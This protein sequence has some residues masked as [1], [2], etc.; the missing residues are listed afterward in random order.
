MILSPTTALK[1]LQHAIVHADPAHFA[2]CRFGDGSLCFQDENDNTLLS[3]S[4]GFHLHIPVNIIISPA[5]YSDRLCDVG[6]LPLVPFS[7]LI[8]RKL[9]QWDIASR[10]QDQE[11][12]RRDLAKDIRAML[13]LLRD[14]RDLHKS[15][16]PF[17][18]RLHKISKERVIRFFAS[19]SSFR[20]EWKK[21][22][23]RTYSEQ[24]DGPIL[25]QGPVKTAQKENPVPAEAGGSSLAPTTSSQNITD[26][27]MRPHAQ[28]R[29][30]SQPIIASLSA[31]STT[32]IAA[33][34]PSNSN[35]TTVKK[36]ARAKGP[37]VPFS[38]IR[39]LAA[40]AAVGALHQL[41][42]PCA[43][44][45]SFACKLYGNSRIPN[46]GL[47]TLFIPIPKH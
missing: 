17:D 10:Q 4:R 15:Q 40:Q 38:R 12:R 31:P 39:Q 42:L 8:L 21:I 43:I 28:E 3:F 11:S 29:Q 20:K 25:S 37:H 18:A 9:E 22:G 27:S 13:K 46:V 45:G 14:V 16:P 19:S 1:R 7:Y 2:F 5:S 35:A 6:G 30:P 47:H 24:T 41:G 44:F 36:S 33:A 23:F 34:E 32:Y 26:A